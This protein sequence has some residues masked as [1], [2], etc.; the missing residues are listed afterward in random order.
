MRLHFDWHKLCSGY[1]VLDTDIDGR[2]FIGISHV[3]EDHWT[4]RDWRGPGE[5]CPRF[6]EDITRE[7]AEFI[8]ALSM[9]EVVELVD[10][11][12]IEPMLMRRRR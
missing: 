5:Q 6:V 11:K 9:D 12:F 8:L 4:L 1:W 3:T 10:R 2:D 7:E